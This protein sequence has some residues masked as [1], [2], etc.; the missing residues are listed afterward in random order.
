MRLVVW[1]CNMALD[2]KLP[3]LLQLEPDVA[4]VPECGDLALDRMQAVKRSASWSCWRGE[5]PNKGLAVLAFGGIRGETLRPVGSEHRYFI[6]IRF[7]AP[8]DLTLVAVWTQ[9]R[10]GLRGY[11]P[12]LLGGVDAALRNLPGREAVVAG[13]FNTMNVSRLEEQFDVRSA[14]HCFFQEDAERESRNTAFNK[15]DGAHGYHLD[16]VCVPS[17]WTSRIKR[18]EVGAWRQ[19]RDVSDHVPVVVDM[20]VG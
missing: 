2:R 9:S 18:V 20:D 3:R 4:V 17:R 15:K 6:P 13:D 8:L 1:N 16:Y 5:N 10:S 12:A 7:A 14:Y 19:W 11:R